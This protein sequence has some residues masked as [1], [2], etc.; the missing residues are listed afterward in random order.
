MRGGNV[1][2][3]TGW[4][5]DCDVEISDGQIVAVR[6]HLAA[7]QA[8]T[9]DVHGHSV[10]SG[11]FD[12]HLH[13][14]GGAMFEDGQADGVVHISD[15]L[16][17]FGTTAVLAT[18]AALPPE[19]LRAA[20]TAI[21]EAAPDCAGARIA[22]IH[23][24][25][26]FIN[27]QRAGA[28]SAAWMR[29]PS[30][31]EFEALQEC[32][33]GMIRL[34]TVAP[35]LPG[36]IDFIAAARARG[37][38]V[39]LGHSQASEGQV[40]S[41]IAAGATHVTHLFNATAPLHHRAPGLL[42]TA[43]TDDRLFIEL[44]CDGEHVHPRAIDIA[45][46]CKPPDKIV[47]VSDGVAAVGMPAGDLELFGV[48][49]ISRESVRVRASGQ[50]AG[51]NATLERAVRLLRAWFPAAPLDRFLDWA[52]VT[53]ARLL[54]LVSAGLVPGARADLVVLDADLRVS[55]SVCGGRLIRAHATP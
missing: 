19:R 38:V 26:P 21:A 31:D 12:I 42:G 9:V 44:I 55:A 11:F 48:P 54:G 10:V 16:A 49:C 3:P 35:E 51:S 7:S 41:A 28:Q 50:L 52:T 22:G 6:P 45:L 36:A 5:A 23:L 14:A 27:P 46:R 13:G 2:T 24:E 37:V 40:L 53:P 43:L 15:V 34:I 32:S 33:G 47:L 30:V 4:I 39:A 29:P 17:Q 1:R 18:L 25:G 20:A 8:D